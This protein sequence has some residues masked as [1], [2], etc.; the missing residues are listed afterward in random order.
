VLQS[1]FL[2]CIQLSPF[3]FPCASFRTNSDQYTWLACPGLSL[4]SSSP[5]F[6]ARCNVRVPF[7]FS[8]RPDPNHSCNRLYPLLQFSLTCRFSQF[9]SL[10]AADVPLAVI[11]F[12][13]LLNSPRTCCLIFVFGACPF[14]LFCTDM[15]LVWSPSNPCFFIL[16]LNFLTLKAV[17]LLFHSECRY[18]LVSPLRNALYCLG[19]ILRGPFRAF[20]F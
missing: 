4:C 1:L 6:L 17:F 10:S 11:L 7:F 9:C 20:P 18:V 3:P 8:R 16:T 5:D 13:C 12:N 19:L 2:S 14:F 15:P